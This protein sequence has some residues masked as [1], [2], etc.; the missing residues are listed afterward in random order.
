MVS[1][2]TFTSPPQGLGR[3]TPKIDRVQQEI[4]DYIESLEKMDAGRT[5]IPVQEEEEV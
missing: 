5:K 2:P 1:S 3:R 4:Y